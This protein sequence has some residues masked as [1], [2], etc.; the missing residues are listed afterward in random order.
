MTRRG[1]RY[2]GGFLNTYI[3][4]RHYAA[5]GVSTGVGI[6]LTV[7]AVASLAAAGVS[8]A[9][10]IQQSKNQSALAKAMQR[11]K[12]TEAQ[13]EAEAAAFEE[14]QSRRRT[15]LL[16]GKQQAI[17]AASG[18][19]TTTGSPL[20]QELDLT[21]QAELEALNIRRGGQVTSEASLFESR[22]AKY[23]SDTAKAAIP[24]EITSGVLSGVGS[25]AS[26]YGSA[27]TGTKKTV[28]GDWY[29]TYGGRA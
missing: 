17:F 25:A 2:F 20:I 18:L 21:T 1:H 26:I 19:E 27:G 3:E 23:Q 8:S 15:A 28:T 11:Q 24:Y 6:A 29:N 16:L 13:N 12:E 5:L 22:I 14:R 4:E 7:A 10:A 9:A